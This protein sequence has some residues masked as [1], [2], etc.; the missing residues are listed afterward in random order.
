ML[1][2]A[3]A[4]LISLFAPFDTPSITQADAV[5]ACCG[6]PTKLTKQEQEEF[7]RLMD[8]PDIDMTGYP[9]F[10]ECE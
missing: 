9:G 10:R 8:N 7:N 3:L 4:I 1:Q 6:T 5:A 2:L